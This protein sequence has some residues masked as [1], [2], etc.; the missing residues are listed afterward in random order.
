MIK[1]IVAKAALIWKLWAAR[2]TF[3]SAY[4]KMEKTINKTSKSEYIINHT[5]LK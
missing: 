1:N 5:L 3:D 2:V 4:H